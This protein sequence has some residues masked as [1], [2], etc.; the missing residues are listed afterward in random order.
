MCEVRECGCV[1]ESERV[2]V[3]VYESKRVVSVCESV[4]VCESKRV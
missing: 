1:C 3:C 4:C 2:R